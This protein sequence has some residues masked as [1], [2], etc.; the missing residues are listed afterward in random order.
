[1]VLGED[2][3]IAQAKLAADRAREEEA[4]TEQDFNKLAG[5]IQNW[6]NGGTGETG[7]GGETETPTPKIPEGLKVGSTVEYNPSG[8]YTWQAKYCSST[9]GETENEELSSGT[10]G[11]FNISSWKV[12]S[13]DAIT[14][15]VELVPSAPTEGE[16]YLGEAQGYNNA[17]KLL[18]EACSNLY[19]SETKKITARSISMEDIEKYMTEEAVEEA[20]RYYDGKGRGCNLR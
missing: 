5:D 1:M 8:T 4:R 10:E 2:G 14:G 3:I 17:V 18:N 15:N 16:V 11:Q 20:H 19:G 13:I 9:K 12:L 7:S 6:V